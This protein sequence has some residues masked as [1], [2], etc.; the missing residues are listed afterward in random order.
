[1]KILTCILLGVLTN[2][3]YRHHLLNFFK[4]KKTKQMNWIKKLINKFFKK[5]SEKEREERLNSYFKIIYYPLTGK[6]FPVY[7]SSYLKKVMGTGIIIKESYFP[8]AD[9]FNTEEEARVY[10]NLYKEQWLTIN[11]KIIKV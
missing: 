5:E 9:C 2:I 11:E 1:M 8:V 4:L 3:L 7:K 10:I 6:Y